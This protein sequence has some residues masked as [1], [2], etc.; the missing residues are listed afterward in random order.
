MVEVEV[1]SK[2]L[3]YLNYNTSDYGWTENWERKNC[4]SASVIKESL[5]WCD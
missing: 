1:L 4:L 5:E 2:L 3:K